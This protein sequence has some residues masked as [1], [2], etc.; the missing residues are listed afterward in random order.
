MFQPGQSGNPE[1]ARLQ[2]KPFRAALVRRLES[3]GRDPAK[4]DKLADALV[5]Q[6]ERG[7]GWALQMV[8]DR[9]DGKPL[10]A[11]TNETT[12]RLTVE[13]VE[14]QIIEPGRLLRTDELP[15]LLDVCTNVGTDNTEPNS[16]T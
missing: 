11:T 8:A 12:Y 14:R 2:D 15:K 6:A 13:R 10:Q 1:G 5:K 3:A 9:L 4:L 7:E 16:S